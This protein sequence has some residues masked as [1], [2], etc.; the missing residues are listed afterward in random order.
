VKSH[1]KGYTLI[2]VIV[3]ISIF[4]VMIMLAGTAMNQ[5]LQQYRGLMEK[6]LDF[7]NYAR[8]IWM[9]KSFNSATDYYVRTR[10]DG[11]FPYFHGDR[12]G[13]SYVSLAPFTGELPVVV[14]IKKEQDEQG[15]LTLAYYELPVYTKTFDDI[16]RDSLAQ[17]YKKGQRV[18]ML[19]QVDSL[20]FSFY[21]YDATKRRY[22]WFNSF[23][24]HRMKRLPALLRVSYRQGESEGNLVFNLNVNS[25]Q[26]TDYNATYPYVQ[27]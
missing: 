8:M 18:Q 17:D 3:A 24:G 10:S 22:E 19:E 1:P 14:W 7:W 23:E 11:W 12:A 9:D 4:S 2:E 15:L 16:E 5:G 6:G 13:V 21:G 25:L 27:K 26:K 20:S